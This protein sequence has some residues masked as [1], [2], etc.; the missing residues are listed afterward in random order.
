MISKLGEPLT[1]PCG[2]VLPN[3]I[4]KAAMTEGLADRLNRATERHVRLYERW[5][6]S[7]A[8]ML[9]TGNVQVDRRYLERPGNVAWDGNGGM[10][11]LRAFAVAAKSGGAPAWMQLG[12]AGRQTPRR[13]SDRPVAPSA[14]PLAL[15]EK[16]FAPPRA[17][18]AEEIAEIPGRF[19]AAADA[20]Q[21]AGFDGIQIHAAHG[22]LISEFLSPLANK[23]TDRWG[24]PLENRARLL[25][26]S[27]VAVRAAVG[28]DFP[29]CVKLNSSDFQKGGFTHA[30][31]L[32][33]VRWL[34]EAGIDL[35]EISGGNYEQPALIGVGGE[36]DSTPVKRSTR[37]REAYFLDFA[38][39]VREVATMP[40]M[41]TGG[42]RSRTV[43]EAALDDGACDMIGIARPMCVEWDL[44]ARLLDGSVDAGIA[45]ERRI[46]PAKAQMHW[47]YW[48]LFRMGDG[49]DP[50]PDISGEEAAMLFRRREDGVAAA[51]ERAKDRS[52]A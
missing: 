11:E 30:E 44:P 2:A 15:P 39:S 10:E 48:Q 13:V 18:E 4:C 14:V 9:L 32:E 43:M 7:G 1:L 16:L 5:G 19:A 37:E 22:Y 26:D 42:F 8:G 17:L 29:V 27:V 51:L 47:F 41:V 50:D 31:C 3:R 6:R 12:H 49:K 40:L 36:D 23:R 33:V 35:L 20:A 38:Q 28:T 52:A 46:E 45:F 21:E 25:L 34:G 24:G